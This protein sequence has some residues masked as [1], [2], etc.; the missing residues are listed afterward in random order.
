MPSFDIVSEVD[1][2]QL[3]NAVDNA[4]RI[5]ETRFDFKGI[6]ASFERG[7]PPRLARAED[8][9]DAS[10]V[11]WVLGDRGFHT[12]IHS[13]IGS[14]ATAGRVL[15]QGSLLIA[16]GPDGAPFASLIAGP[17]QEVETAARRLSG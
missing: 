9:T 6:Q 5:I 13:G 3:T 2:H 11:A 14:P 12:L 17:E 8:A 16:L 15:E 7:L 10:A 4:N 1:L